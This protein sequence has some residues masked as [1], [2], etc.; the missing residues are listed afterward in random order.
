MISINLFYYWKNVLPLE[1]YERLQRKNTHTKKPP[2]KTTTM[3]IFYLKKKTFTL[4]IL[5]L[6]IKR[7]G[8]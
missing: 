6:Q 4:K 1:I 2:A 7:T 8:K 3:K 5:L